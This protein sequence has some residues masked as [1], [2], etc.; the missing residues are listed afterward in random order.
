MSYRS[1]EVQ[2]RVSGSPSQRLLYRVIAEVKDLAIVVLDVNGVIVAGNGGTRLLGE[3]GEELLGRHVSCLY[4]GE[5]AEAGKPRK[6]LEIASHDGQYCSEGLYVRRGGERFWAQVRL[7]ALRGSA[8]EPRGFICVITDLTDRKAQKDRE[9][10]IQ[11]SVQEEKSW[12]QDLFES[13]PDGYVV[14]SPTGRIEVVNRTACSMLGYAPA[15][16]YECLLSDLLPEPHIGEFHQYLQALTAGQSLA[17]WDVQVLRKDGPP[18]WAAVTASATRDAQGQVMNLR[19]LIRDMTRERQA[20]ERLRASEER[21]AAATRETKVGVFDWNVI[22]GM[23]LWSEEFEQLFGFDTSSGPP[24]EMVVRS[25]DHWASRI[26][27]DDVAGFWAELAHAKATHVMAEKDFRVIWPDGSLHWLNARGRYYYDEHG[28]PCRLLGTARDITRK[29]ETEQQL[30]QT[31]EELARSNAELE[32]FAHVASHDLREPLGVILLYLTLLKKRLGPV[33]GMENAGFIEHAMGAADRMNKLISNL[34]AYSRVGRS[35]AASEP[36]D[37]NDVLREAEENLEAAVSQEQ[38]VVIH[39]PLPVIRAEKPLM[40]QLLQNLIG[41]AVKYRSPG[42]PPQIEV[43]ARREGNAWLFWVRDSGVGIAPVD[44]D[45]IFMIFQRIQAGQQ[46][47]G[48]GIGLAICKKIVEHHCGRIWVESQPGQGATF[49]FT[50]PD[51]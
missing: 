51:R 8:G 46:S 15:E 45:R 39:Q 36:T 28:Q 4:A 43:G 30:E 35:G 23:S 10:S 41:N 14:T 27:P 37:M 22:T 25:R 44:H 13:A 6:D 5:D 12:Y 47:P 48:A 32:H 24:A 26:H 18:F 7:I 20:Q 42:K 16:L 9:E 40:T 29:K 33:I 21:L 38:A 49:F 50:I 11:S 17:P 3:W 31:A 1:D 19:W 34:L 2:G